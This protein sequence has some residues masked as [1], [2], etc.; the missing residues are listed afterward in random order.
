MRVAR[1]RGGSL[2]LVFEFADAGAELMVELLLLDELRGLAG[3]RRLGLSEFFSE[4][5][6]EGV[7]GASDAGFGVRDA[8]LDL[9]E[10][11]QHGASALRIKTEEISLVDHKVGLGC[12]VGKANRREDGSGET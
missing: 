11:A 5:R 3:E 7:P 6:D 9:F 1:D 12:R 2:D 4:S 8:A 10:V